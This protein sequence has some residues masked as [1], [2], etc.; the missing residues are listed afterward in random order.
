MSNCGQYDD[1]C[2]LPMYREELLKRHHTEVYWFHIEE[3]KKVEYNGKVIFEKSTYY[4]D[5]AG[6][7][8]P[9]LFVFNRFCPGALILEKHHG[10]KV[11]ILLRSKKNK[12]SNP[13]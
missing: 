10:R 5:R 9:G 2:F 6:G 7:I 11:G 8:L 13:L 3:I 1:L 12:R 4:K